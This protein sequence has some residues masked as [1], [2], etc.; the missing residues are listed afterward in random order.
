MIDKSGG[1]S[2]DCSWL[3]YF[4]V[5]KEGSNQL[6]RL[7]IFTHGFGISRSKAKNGEEKNHAPS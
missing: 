7:I 3:H 6:D 1:H 5:M 2:V 4:A